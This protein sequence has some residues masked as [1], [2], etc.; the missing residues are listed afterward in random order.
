MH[1]RRHHPCRLVLREQVEQDLAQQ[2]RA[3]H[4]ALQVGFQ[5]AQEARNSV[6]A[7][8]QLSKT[9]DKPVELEQFARPRRKDKEITAQ[10]RNAVYTTF[11]T[12]LERE[13]RFVV[14]VMS[15]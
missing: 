1:E 5:S 11:V 9:I 12:A 8:V 10:I 7:L 13:E 3:Q 15:A 2:A 4:A 14:V 6:Q